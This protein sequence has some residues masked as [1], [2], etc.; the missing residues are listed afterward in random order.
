M[1]KGFLIKK[2]TI[3]DGTGNRPFIN[4]VLVEGSVIKKISLNIDNDNYDV[5]NGEG[6][7][8]CPGIIDTHSHSDLEVFRNKDMLHVIRQG[9]TTEVTGQDGSSVAPL[10]LI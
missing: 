1:S 7:A 2:A 9:I 10:S 4:D 5:I 3:Y 8:L 6:Y